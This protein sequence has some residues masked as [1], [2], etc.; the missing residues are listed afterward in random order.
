[1]VLGAFRESAYD[2][3]SLAEIAARIEASLQH[4]EAVEEFV[5]V[6]LAQ[7]SGDG[8]RAE[9]LNCGHPP[10]LLVRDGEVTAAEPA[11]AGLPLGLAALL[12]EARDVCTIPLRCRG[13]EGAP[14][15]PPRSARRTRRTRTAAAPA[16]ALARPRRCVRVH[17]CEHSSSRLRVAGSPVSSVLWLHSVKLPE[18]GSSSVRSVRPLSRAAGRLA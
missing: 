17:K 11:Q 18:D 9:L 12:P 10:P 16:A 8:C 14:Q 13:P 7:V 4:Q 5:T 6:V 2:A 1:M 3:A 15:P